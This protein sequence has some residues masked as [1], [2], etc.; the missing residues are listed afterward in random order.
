MKL[1]EFVFEGQKEKIKLSVAQQLS[2]YRV[3]LLLCAPLP[4]LFR[5]LNLNSGENIL[6]FLSFD[7]IFCIAFIIVFSCSFIEVISKYFLVLSSFLFSGFTAYLS[8]LGFINDF[9]T[10]IT[11]EFVLFLGLSAQ[12][13]HKKPFLSIYIILSFLFLSIFSANYFGAGIELA[14][15]LASIGFICFIIH[16]FVNYR[17]KK[18]AYFTFQDNLLNCFFNESPDALIIVDPISLKIFA[19]N[20]KAAFIFG[21]KTSESL[22]NRDGKDFLEIIFSNPILNEIKTS[23]SNTKAFTKEI[24]L[25]EAA[26]IQWGSFAIKEVSLE[27]NL[28][29]LIRI[30][31]VSEKI[32]DKRIIE[33]NRKMLRQ[34]IDLVPHP[35]FLKDNDGRFIFVNKS[36]GALY[37]LNLEQIV[38]RNDL[39][40]FKTEEALAFIKDDKEVIESGEVKLIE[41]EHFTDSNGELHKFHTTKIPFFKEG[42]KLPWVLGISIDIGERIRAKESIDESR[43][44]LMEIIN[45]LPHEIY[46]K[47]PDGVI[48]LANEACAAIHG[49]NVESILGK[50]D[51]DLFDSEFANEF[52]EIEL[53]I[54]QTGKALVITE[55]ISTDKRGNTYI[56]SAHKTPFFFKDS[57]KMGILGINIDITQSKIAEKA[58]KESE[59]KYRMLMDQASDG[60][61]LSNGK[62]NIVEANPKACE[63]LG[64]TLNEILALNIKDLMDPTGDGDFP[65]R[66][67]SLDDQS[68]VIL[69]RRFIKK[70]GTVFNV[71][72]SVKILDEGMHQAI[73]RDIT[74][75]K[76]VEGILKDSE[77]KFRALIENSSDIILILSEDLIIKY[78]S[79]SANRILGYETEF[80]IGKNS[81]E[82]IHNDDLEL[83]GK[84]VSLILEMPDENQILEEIRVKNNVGEYKIFEVVAVNKLTDPFING[85]IVNCH[86]IT[87]RKNTEIELIHTNFELDSFVYKASHDLKAPLRSVMGL[88]KLA[89]IESKDLNLNVYLDMMN[90]SVLSLDL[91]IRD[92]THFSRNSRMEVEGKIIDFEDIILDT[93]H[94]LRFM[95]NAEK[96]EIIQDLNIDQEFYSDKSRI[97]TIISNLVSNAYKYHRFEENK[98][99][100]KI[101]VTTSKENVIIVVEDNGSG[102]DT[103]HTD[104]IFDMFY[105]A[106][107]KSYGSG[108]GLYIVKSAI[109]K[110][111]GSITVESELSKGTK[112]KVVL[113]NLKND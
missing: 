105:R 70:D 59:T 14:L 29:W 60:I 99:F 96:V 113:P 81:M 46:L 103:L 12:V 2:F 78:V 65:A 95:E 112:F 83:V 50:S 97:S 20:E 85:I 107:E 22:V 48:I 110:L 82:F 106:S 102:I 77:R 76:K 101:S 21:Q 17:N 16:F 86:D 69:E 68:S 18:K 49:L 27:R 87:K 4:L 6:Q 15:F 71:E 109:N 35:I 67:P 41:G 13:L 61:Y 80:L 30:S 100:I 51:F 91:F 52:R 104:K 98:P 5:I 53:E 56:K 74:E 9:N 90:K 84:V 89:K 57:G 1:S 25:G 64:Y 33:E 62:G 42:E 39:E 37:N 94:N 10:I 24:A 58:L 66:L 8:Y 32:E 108:L 63:M 43:K 26:K 7:V 40:I 72:L 73:I 45:S 79:N 88:I 34:V 36:F 19:A 54:M 31:D 111:K 47:N 44:M 75:R 55:E 38:G 93:I 23:I 92:L 28:F 3:M 11:L